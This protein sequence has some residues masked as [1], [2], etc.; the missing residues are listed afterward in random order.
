[1]GRLARLGQIGF[2]LIGLVLAGRPGGVNGQLPCAEVLY[3]AVG[4]SIITCQMGSPSAEGTTVPGDL[5]RVDDQRAYQFRVGPE[6]RSAYIYLGDQWYDMEAGLYRENL[7]QEIARWKFLRASQETGSRVLQFVQPD[8]IVR[9]MEPNTN[10]L[11]VVQTAGEVGFDPSKGFTLR[12]ALGAPICGDKL[13]PDE[14]YLV[15]ITF[16]PEKPGPFDLMTF[17]VNVAP[18]Y[19]DLFDFDWQIDGRPAGSGLTIQQPVPGLQKTPLGAHKVTVT[20]KGARVYPDPDQP[21]IPLDGGSM[22]VDCAFV[23]L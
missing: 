15:T 20:A 13:S 19:S 3:E 23:A 5:S 4:K 14:R 21:S 22:A 9:S 2:L 1:M 11:L 10:Y 16:Q 8:K 6:P 17:N 7:G 12:V 18:P